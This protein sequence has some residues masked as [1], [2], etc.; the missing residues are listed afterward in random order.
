MKEMLDTRPLHPWHDRLENLPEGKGDFY[1]W[2]PNYTVDP[3][4]IAGGET[5][6]VLLIL[7]KKD[8][9]WALPGGFVDPTDANVATAALRELYEETSLQLN[10]TSPELVYEGPV[11]DPRSTREA[12]PETTA[13]LWR[14]DAKQPIHAGDDA[15][16][17]AWAPLSQLPD[18]LYGS[19]A[20]IIR[21]A[22]IDHGSLREQLAYFE[23]QHETIQATGG[24]MNYDRQI[25]TLPIGKR[26]FVKH[27]DPAA[28]TDDVREQHSRAYLR[29]EYDTYRQLAHQ[30][31]HTPQVHEL[32]NDHSL[33]IDACDPRD[34]WLWRAPR[35]NALREQYISE[36][37]S[38]LRAIATINYVDTTD[39]TASCTALDEDGWENYARD[40]SQILARLKQHGSSTAKRLA[41]ELDTLHSEHCNRTVRERNMFAHA[42]LRQ[43]NLAW[44]PV[45]GVRIVDWSWAGASAPGL[46]TTSF[47]IDLAKSNIDISKHMSHFDAIHA[48]RLLGFWLARSIQP[49]RPGTTTRE[50]QL[51]SALTAFS[52]LSEN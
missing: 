13:L 11:E 14:T 9:Q 52:L 19:H 28:F 12:W 30:T 35:D 50:H 39:I 47:L 23:G 36:V 49:A 6:S 24:H 5:P 20:D 15:V 7:R 43:S 21:R 48:R 22:I 2:G 31:T 4:V 38:A 10:D 1:H 27:H 26:V 37:L 40:R 34:G 33:V 8:L 44:H 46:D 25:I 18:D 42:D 16:D 3:V 29:K 41:V 32:I 51:A 45:H 17:A